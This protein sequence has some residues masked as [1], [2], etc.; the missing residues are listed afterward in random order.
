VFESQFAYF[1]RALGECLC[2]SLLDQPEPAREACE[3]AS[4]LLENAVADMPQDPRVHGALGLSYALLGRKDE[5]IR[6]GELAV[7]LWP[8]SK[9]AL[10][11]PAFVRNLAVIYVLAGEDEAALDQIEYVLSIPSWVSVPILRAEPYWDPLRD[12]PR[13]LALLE[14]YET[15]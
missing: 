3:E 12:H 8:V 7:E 15:D 4:V 6:E 13:F 1:P 11:G 14:K 10:K 2:R 5:A 9:D